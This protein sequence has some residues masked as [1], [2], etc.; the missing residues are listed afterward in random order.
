[1]ARVNQLLAEHGVNIEGQLL[2]TRGS[3]GYALTD[4]A[5]DLPP[6]AL[7]ALAAVPE[8]IS[9]RVVP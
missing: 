3:L 8:T 1:M 2:S 9:T 7:D 4:V 5:V 6:G